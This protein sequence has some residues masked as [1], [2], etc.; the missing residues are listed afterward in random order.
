MPHEPSVIPNSFRDLQVGDMAKHSYFVYMLS[1][2]RRTVLYIGMTDDL[3]QR[4]M[5]HRKGKVGWFTKK[6]NGL[7]E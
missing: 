5:E 3:A 2:Q 7:S 1:N 6:H 4:I